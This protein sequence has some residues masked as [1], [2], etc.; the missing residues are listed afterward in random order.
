[1]STADEQPGQWPAEDDLP[2]EELARRQGVKAVASLNELAQPDLWESD[3][4]YEGVPLRPL[5]LPQVRRRVSFVVLDTDVASAILRERVPT[6][7]NRQLTRRS[8]AITFVTVGELTRWT[9]V[10]HGGPQRMAGMRAF[11][12]HVVVLPYSPKVAT[13]S[14]R[15]SETRRH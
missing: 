10:R 14:R 8:L 7:L 5:R 13:A 6:S 4:E 2:I 1:M 12:A 11:F 9:L 3:E 15:D